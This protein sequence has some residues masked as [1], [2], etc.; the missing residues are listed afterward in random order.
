[1]ITLRAR[2]THTQVKEPLG[3]AVWLVVDSATLT[4][5][6]AGRAF[7]INEGDDVPG[8]FDLYLTRRGSQGETSHGSEIG[9]PA[10]LDHLA[11]GDVVSVNAT[12][13]M[14]N[15]L[16][17]HE[18]RQNSVLLTERCDHYCL[19]CSQ[20]PKQGNDDWL[21][22]NAFELIRL[23][24]RT[25]TDIAFTGGEPTLYGGE[26]LKLLRLCRNLLPF[27]AVHVLSNG[28]RFRDLTFASR[29]AAVDNP[30][31][32]VGIPLYG[33]EPALHH[34]VVQAS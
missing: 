33:A 11:G 9:L 4:S 27:A 1:M 15:V 13:E 5:Q 30:N 20:P 25:T 14:I 6:R 3:R 28:R 17:R 18:S 23:L 12:G 10:L 2:A 7:L 32:M 29:W 19:M 8:E 34:Y 24:P 21:L 31:M 22:D 16:W 26:L